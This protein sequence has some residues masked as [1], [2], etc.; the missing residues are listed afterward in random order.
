MSISEN[1]KRIRTERG[2]SSIELSEMVGVSQPMI[3]LI[4]RG[5][6]VPGLALARDLAQALGTTV[7]E[8][9]RED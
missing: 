6:K 3:T 7:D 9:L 8:L 5:R 1:L 4:E 2:L